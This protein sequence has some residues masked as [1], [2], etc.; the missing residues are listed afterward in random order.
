MNTSKSPLFLRN[1]GRA[2]VKC[3]LPSGWKPAGASGNSGWTDPNKAN[4]YR[5]RRPNKFPV[6]FLI[7]SK[8]IYRY[9][10]VLYLAIIGSFCG[11]EL[12]TFLGDTP[13]FQ[14]GTLLTFINALWAVLFPAIL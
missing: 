3:R 12:D 8:K 1:A 5:S 2:K 4:D 7:M 14:L 10:S 13:F 9:F 11:M 6:R